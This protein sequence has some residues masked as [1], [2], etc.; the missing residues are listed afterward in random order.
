MKTVVNRGVVMVKQD[1]FDFKYIEDQV[2]A[3]KQSMGDINNETQDKNMTEI[4]AEQLKILREINHTLENIL[5]NNQRKKSW[6]N[7]KN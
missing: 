1:L 7:F 2:S 3:I 5:E 6:F 4:L